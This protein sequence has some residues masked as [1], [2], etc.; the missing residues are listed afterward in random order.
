M[1]VGVILPL[2]AGEGQSDPRPYA[3]LR[4]LAL[5]AEGDGFD[6]VW[7]YDHLLYRFPD[8]PQFGI[9]ESWTLFS[10]LC[11][12]TSR[13]E[14]GQL[15]M[16]A[17]W[18]NPALLAKMAITA[19]E[20]S[21]GRVI[22]GLGAG[23]HQPEFEAFGYPFHHLV[24][25]FEE[26]L[27]IVGPLLRDGVADVQGEFFTA[28]DAAMIPRGP[29]PGSPPILIASRGPRMLR[30]TAEHA[31]MWNAAWFGGTR[32]FEERL[33]EMMSACEAAGRDPATLAITVGINVAFRRPGEQAEDLDP[34]HF[35]QGTPEEV[36]HGI[37][38]FADRGVAHAICNPSPSN[39]AGFAAL[40]EAL[41]IYREL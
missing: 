41:A 6:S 22:L 38:A 3:E 23:W 8:R 35:L 29:R 34:D 36:A 26:A 14:L 31:D 7:V 17:A 27:S 20:V 11:E 4:D 30:L 24:G 33:A 1:K 5:Q 32:L 15:V 9:W 2:G 13:V 16:C 21:G 10:A 25:Q 39:S 19:D 18:R 28:N 40:A 12:A 37:K